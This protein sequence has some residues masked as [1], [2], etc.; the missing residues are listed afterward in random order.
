MDTWE[1]DEPQVT[2]V[3]KTLYRKCPTLFDTLLSRS[4]Q[5]SLRSSL[6]KHD[7][8]EDE[9]ILQSDDMH[10]RVTATGRLSTKYC[11]EILHMPNRASDSLMTTHFKSQL[12]SAFAE[13][14]GVS[15]VIYFGAYSFQWCRKIS[16]TSR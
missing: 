7:E 13:D 14:Y 15:N 2:A 1:N 3:V 4:D 8:E 11:T 10:K 5:E 12:R 9:I 6:I 16:F